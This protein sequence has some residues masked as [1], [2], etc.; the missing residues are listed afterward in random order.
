[1]RLLANENFPADAVNALREKGH[2]VTWIRTVAPGSDDMGVLARAQKENR[3]LITFDK[4]FGEL[5]FHSRLP[6]T[7]GVIL[8]RISA[9]SSTH[10]ARA[11]VE[12][13]S[14]RVDWAGH[15]SVIED[16]RIRMTPLPKRGT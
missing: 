5:A 15:F 6:A 9:P 2:D 16:N 4:D 10:V 3:I 11:A 7:S 14:S 1:M 8:F 12:A 13:I